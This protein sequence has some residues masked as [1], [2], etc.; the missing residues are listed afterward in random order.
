MLKRVMTIDETDWRLLKLANEKGK[1]A[2]SLG[3]IQDEDLQMA[4]ERG[5]D[6]EWFSLVDFS[7]V[8]QAVGTGL[9]RIFRLTKMGW[10]RRTEVEHL[11]TP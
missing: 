9:L 5:I 10:K 1:F 6:A 3:S 8:S 2:L 7:P 4:F 11:D